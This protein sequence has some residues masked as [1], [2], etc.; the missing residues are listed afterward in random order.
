MPE[1]YFDLASVRSRTIRWELITQRE[2]SDGRG[3]SGLKRGTADTGDP[4]SISKCKRDQAWKVV[5][6]WAYG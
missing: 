5:D 3:F 1:E 2:D 6:G 4:H